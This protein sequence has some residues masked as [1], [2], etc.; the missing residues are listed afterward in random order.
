M[1][2]VFGH[3]L[4]ARDWNTSYNVTWVG[5][6]PFIEH[7]KAISNTHSRRVFIPRTRN[8]TPRSEN[9]RSLEQLVSSPPKAKNSVTHPGEQIRKKKKKLSFICRGTLSC[10][11]ST[12]QPLQ[13]P[14]VKRLSIYTRN[15]KSICQV[16]SNPDPASSTLKSNRTISPPPFHQRFQSPF[17]SGLDATM[18]LTERALSICICSPTGHPP[19]PPSSSE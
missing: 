12:K 4:G 17:P 10:L 6:I 18:M 7:S 15:F 11:T 8:I 3:D 19:A 14:V 1:S 16:L 5:P 2:V 9:V 13:H